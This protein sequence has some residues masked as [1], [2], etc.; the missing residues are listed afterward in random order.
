MKR[1][2]I[3]AGSLAILPLLPTTALAAA[4]CSF[5]F[6]PNG[7]GYSVIFDSIDGFFAQL[8]APATC[9]VEVTV[10]PVL[11][12]E[13][14]VYKADYRGGL[15]LNASGKIA[16][17]TGNHA[18]SVVV[19]TGDESFD[20]LLFSDFVG[21]KDGDLD[22]AVALSLLKQKYPDSTLILDS[23]DYVEL[24]RTTTADLQTSANQFAANHTSLVTHLNAT[25]DLLTGAGQ[26]LEQPDGVGGLGGIGS[27]TAGLTGRRVLGGNFTA[28]GGAAVL[29]QSS[30]G[31]RATGLLFSGS[32]RYLTPDAGVF[33]PFAEAG[34]RTSPVLDMSFTRQTKTTAG[35][36]T[37]TATAV[38][39]TFGGYLRAGV[40]VAPDLGNELVFSASLAKDWVHTGAYAETVTASN[41]FA[42]SAAAQT[43]SFDTIK[44]GADWTTKAVPGIDLTVS[45]AVGRTIAE[46]SVAT[47]VAF[48]GAFSG[49]ARSENFVEYGLRAGREVVEGTNVGVFVHGATGDYSGTHVQVGGDFHV[50]F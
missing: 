41:L 31:A 39:A 37:G 42:L 14:A 49:A 17:K 50:R 16:V 27:F 33:R 47:K 15:D 45:A 21:T 38:G 3:I 25:A 8:G 20:G 7:D 19:T 34:V 2:A 48:A 29:D 26:Q 43:S 4:D 32:I 5:S 44:L 11:A 46:D 1:L 24:G 12:D 13:I 35:T 10:D 6:T 40:L 36:Q 23:I 28:L 30:N 9:P 22:S 18:A